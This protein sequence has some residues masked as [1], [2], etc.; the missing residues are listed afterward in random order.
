MKR[1]ILVAQRLLCTTSWHPLDATHLMHSDPSRTTGGPHRAGA[2]WLSGTHRGAARA[3]GGGCG[4]G[5]Q[6]QGKCGLL[7][8]T[9]EGP[10]VQGFSRG[11][12]VVSLPCVR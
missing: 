9:T 10:R 8:R 11:H 3:A 6:V 12:I 2:V 7:P 4:Q 1:S 5:E